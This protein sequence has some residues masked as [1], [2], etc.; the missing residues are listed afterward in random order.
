MSP[1]PKRELADRSEALARF[2][3]WAAEHPMS[4]PPAAAVAAAARLYDLL[5]LESRGR[6]VDPSGVMALH[7]MLAR[8]YPIE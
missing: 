1:S 8:L 2:D 5:P 6:A 4:L 3:A 7:G